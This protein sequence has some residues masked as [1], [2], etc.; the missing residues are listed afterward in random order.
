MSASEAG[1]PARQ[2]PQVFMALPSPNTDTTAVF[3]ACLADLARLVQADIRPADGTHAWAQAARTAIRTGLLTRDTLD[4]RFFDA[5]INAG[6]YEP[7]PSANAQFIRPAIA[8][9]GRQRVQAALLEFLRHGTNPERAGA[10]RAWYWTRASQTYVGN[11][12]AEW[13]GLAYLHAAWREAALREFISNE[14]IDVRR[15]ILP[16]LPLSTERYPADL[17][18]LV[19]EAIRIARDH[20]DEYLRHRVEIQIHV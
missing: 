9:F 6:V 4:E 13:D 16:G 19:G 8:A 11:N 2:P 12:R 18:A 5:L 10:A 15:C 14:D 7:D 20:P 1:D 3:H 17:H